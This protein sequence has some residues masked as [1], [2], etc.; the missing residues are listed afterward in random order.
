[1]GYFKF[2]FPGMPVIGY[3]ELSYTDL[4]AKLK[5]TELIK[6]K[7][8]CSIE[9]AGQDPKTKQPIIAVNPSCPP[10]EELT[11]RLSA[12]YAIYPIDELSAERIDKDFFNFRKRQM[13]RPLTG[14]VV[15]PEQVGG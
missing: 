3:T 13:D 15:S 8:A 7:N 11:I 12:A 14:N 1:M 5:S 4:L 9:I 2:F 6:I 10:D